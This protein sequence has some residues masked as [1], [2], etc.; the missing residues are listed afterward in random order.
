MRGFAKRAIPHFIK[1]FYDY[2]N[3]I[4][5]VMVRGNMKY[6]FQTLREIHFE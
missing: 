6:E 1:I 5:S 2:I 4:N 3:I